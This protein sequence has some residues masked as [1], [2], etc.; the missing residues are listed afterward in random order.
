MTMPTAS[1]R[2]VPLS[3]NANAANSPLRA[4]NSKVKRSYAT[5]QREEPYGQPPPLK[6]QM[7]ENGSHRAA[8]LT[9]QSR[10]RAPVQAQRPRPKAPATTAESAAHYQRIQERD[11]VSWQKQYRARFPRMVFYFDSVSDDV[12][13]KL[14]KL[15]T[16]LGA[17][18]EKFFSI[19]VTHV[20]TTR[21]LPTAEQPPANHAPEPVHSRHNAADDQP[22]TIN[23]SL[24]DCSSESRRR[25][26]LELGNRRAHMQDDVARP[27]TV[28]NNDI[29]Y[30]ARDMG[31]RIYSV[32]K[33]HRILD[34]LLEGDPHASKALG[35][36]EQ[37]HEVNLAKLLRKE[38]LNGPSDRDPRAV[39]KELNYFRGPYIYVYD[40][41][42]KTKPVMV[43]EYPKV[44][45]KTDGEWPQFKTVSQG[46]CPF[47]DESAV[48]T[49]LLRR[50][51]EKKAVKEAASKVAVTDREPLVKQSA[52]PT[53]SRITGKRSREE[54]G[55]PLAETRDGQNKMVIG[56]KPV[57][58]F[59]PPKDLNAKPIDFSQRFFTGR[60][61]TGR[62]LAGEPVAS[63]V[64]PSN[65]T[66]AIRSQMISSNAG[67]PGAKAGISK[68]VHN[69]QKK[70]LQKAN[71]AAPSGLTSTRAVASVQAI[72]VDG[73]SSRSTSVNR[74]ASRMMETTVGESEGKAKQTFANATAAPPQKS[75]KDMKPGYCENC[76]DKFEDFD[77]HIVSRKHRKFADC[78]DNWAE[79]DDLLALLKRPLKYSH[80]DGV[81]DDDNDRIDDFVGGP[82]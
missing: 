33:L 70:V 26:L 59:N 80:L 79:L 48:D 25:M 42:E 32:E 8:P 40:M 35:S 82:W 28:R 38:R 37:S 68:E 81:D 51:M 61:N 75:K 43:R 9:S 34:N 22:Q 65:V 36:R 78:L 19:D 15:I 30:K 54:Y 49:K 16:Y 17:R 44:A 4:T 29:L 60:H 12:R 67:A 53:G 14:V 47:V 24:L 66:S 63:G 77:D 21:P 31:K 20:V 57:D 73:Q 27:K 10:T 5:I 46:R 39:T 2:R 71:P 55:D 74:A 7:L 18:E 3:N 76:Q 13:A 52:D 62:V 69:L 23:P 72:S 11:L 58:V 41:D 45:D 6:K 64:Q 56:V 50:A 1:T